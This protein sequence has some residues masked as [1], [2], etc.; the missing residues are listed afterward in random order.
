M[1]KLTKKERNILIIFTIVA[2]LIRVVFR[3]GESGDYLT[4]LKPWLI[5]IKRLG[6]FFL[7]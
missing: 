6:Y 3:N 1:K 7:I 4:Y 5:D 2:L